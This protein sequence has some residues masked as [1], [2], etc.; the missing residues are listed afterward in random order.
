MVLCWLKAGVQLT[1]KSLL[2]HLKTAPEQLKKDRNAGAA[3][4]IPA[5]CPRGLPAP[6]EIACPDS[7]DATEPHNPRQTVQ[8][9]FFSKLFLLIQLRE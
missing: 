1:N 6:A 3:G 2:K 7:S 8:E 5:L 4:T 9:T